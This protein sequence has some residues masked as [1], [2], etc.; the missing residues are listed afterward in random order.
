M[1]LSDTAIRKA[2]PG[3]HPKHG[4][5]AKPYKLADSGGLYVEVAP[6]G[7]KW[8]RY[9]YRI[10]GKEKRLSLGT[11]PDIGLAEARAKHAEAR[12]LVAFGVDP[13]EQRK[14]DRATAAEVAGN[15][16]PPLAMNYWPSARA[17]WPKVRRYGSAESS[18]TTCALTSVTDPWPK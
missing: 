10:G 6:A 17:S 11:Y 1:P 15:R 12:K 5:T 13:S 3:I 8:W 7:G 4:P 16:S 2:K 14:A 18:T 9:K